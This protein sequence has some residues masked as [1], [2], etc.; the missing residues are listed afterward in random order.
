[1]RGRVGTAAIRALSSISTLV[2]GNNGPLAVCRIGCREGG[3]LV[4]D[5]C[6]IH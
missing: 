1:M 2:R 5:V 3:R 4:S 6:R